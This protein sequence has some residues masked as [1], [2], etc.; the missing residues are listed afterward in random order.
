MALT[1]AQRRAN[2]VASIRKARQQYRQSDTAGER[3]ERELDRL[4][5]RKTLISPEQLQKLTTLYS[6]Y[7]R[8]CSDIQGALTVALTVAGQ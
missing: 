5:K 1:Y 6:D 8:K 2:V 4:I 3:V 7:A